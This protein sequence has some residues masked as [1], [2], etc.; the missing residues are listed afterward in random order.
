MNIFERIANKIR[1]ETIKNKRKDV[2]LFKDTTY[3]EDGN[4]WYDLVKVDPNTFI[5]SCS[6]Y[7]TLLKVSE[8]L[9][10]LHED[11]YLKFIKGFYKSGLDG[12]NKKWQ[13]ADILTVL[14][15]ICSTVRITSYLEIGVRRGRSMAIVASLNSKIDVVGFDLWIDNYAG[16]ENPGKD[17]VKEEMSKLNHTGNLSLVSGDSKKTIPD[18]FNDN[19]SK[20]FD[21]ITVDGDH[22]KRG[23]I[24]DIDNVVPR[25]KIGGFLVFDDINNPNHR[26]LSKVWENKIMKSERFLS[27]EFKGS[28]LGVGFAIKLY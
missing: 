8:I 14:Y 22:S 3:T 4:Q 6:S 24:I 16:M 10:K 15:G 21:L 12:F 7:D 9:E 25:I 11:E 19:P 1:R 26:V 27:H 23:A 2:P 13:Y 28:G 17:F 18:Y 20:Y 5:E